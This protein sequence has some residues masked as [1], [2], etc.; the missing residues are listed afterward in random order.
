M[1]STHSRLL[2]VK[3]LVSLVPIDILPRICD[4]I[5]VFQL[6]SPTNIIFS[7]I[8]VLLLVSIVLDLP[9]TAIMTLGVS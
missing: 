9:V 5:L 7:G 3:V 1:F 2:L 8:G 4:L 6:W